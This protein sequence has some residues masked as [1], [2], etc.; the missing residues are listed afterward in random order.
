MAFDQTK[1]RGITYMNTGNVGFA[2]AFYTINY[3]GDSADWIASSE[4]DTYLRD[5]GVRDND[6][7]FLTCT[8]GNVRVAMGTFLNIG[9]FLA[10]YSAPF[11]VIS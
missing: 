9:G 1:V 8:T 10:V 7:V 4:L 11:T 3:D 5:F 2:P 6:G